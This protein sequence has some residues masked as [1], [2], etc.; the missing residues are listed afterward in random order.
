MITVCILLLLQWGELFQ[1]F[2]PQK[3]E[4]WFLSLLR[5]IELLC[6]V[7]KIQLNTV[8][9]QHKR[10]KFSRTLY[11][12]QLIQF[13]RI[14]VEFVVHLRR[15]Q[16]CVKVITFSM[17]AW[18]LLLI[19]LYSW[20][21]HDLRVQC[22][23]L[24]TACILSEYQWDKSFHFPGKFHFLIKTITDSVRSGV[25]YLNLVLSECVQWAGLR[26]VHYDPRFIYLLIYFI[27]V[28]LTL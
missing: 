27:W 10:C 8:F 14:Y 24:H 13:A 23:E 17:A 9:A 18:Y 26:S 22:L 4:Q 2:Y 25:V 11:N 1:G 6:S 16:N 12:R 3:I 21:L 5:Y 20:C 15:C 19:S 7:T 28:F